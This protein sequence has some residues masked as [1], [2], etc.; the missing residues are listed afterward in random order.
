MEDLP[1][2]DIIAYAIPGFFALI[3]VEAWWAHRERKG[4]YRLN[5]SLADLSCGVVNQLL[6]VFTTVFLVA[7]Y[8][9]TYRNFGMIDLGFQWWVWVLCFIGVDFGYY[10][11]H[12]SYHHHNILWGAHVPHH[13]SEEFNYTVALRQGAF[14][15][16]VAWMFYQP[17]AFLGFPPLMFL[18][19]SACATL[20]Q[21]LPHTQAIDKLPR[22]VESVFNTPSHHRVH[23][24]CDPKYLDRNYGGMLII[25]DKLFGTFQ[26]EEE[27]PTFGTVEPL[28]SWN[29]IWA[30]FEFPLRV[31][32]FSQRYESW[33]EKLELWWLG[34]TAL[35]AVG[36]GPIEVAGRP[37]YNAGSGSGVGAYCVVQFA[38]AL[39]VAVALLF[40]VG[41]TLGQQLALAIWAATTMVSVGAIFE[42]KEWAERVDA[43]RQ[44]ALPIFGFA[45]FGWAGAAV[46]G[47]LA[48]V[49]V[50][51]LFSR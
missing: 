38:V 49:F 7:V 19:V 28:R 1:S 48:L 45:A 10:W 43:L 26:V 18:V 4:L 25:W 29:P 21:F 31:W 39:L 20:Y 46:G 15:P 14:E 9:W 16:L 22:P 35:A 32:T 12:R 33:G 51:W 5:D 3:L 30:N 17:L 23:H 37:Q 42:D 40:G 50:R 8:V 2:V 44:A 24:G 13:S 27:T 41:D 47:G 6:A 11:A 34:P 36:G